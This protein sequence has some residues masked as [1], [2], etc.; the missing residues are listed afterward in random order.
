MKIIH[1]ARLYHPHVGGIEKHLEKINKKFIDKGHS[2]T[3]ITQQYKTNLP[4]KEKKDKVNIIRLARVKKEEFYKNK[5]LYKIQTWLGIFKNLNTL[6]KADII[7][8]HDVMWWLLPFYFLLWNKIYITFH[9]YEGNDE[10]KFNQIFW[11]KLANILTRGNLCVG[12]FHQKWYKVNPTITTFGAVKSLENKSG[13]TLKSKNKK[14]IFIGRLAA[15]NGIINYLKALKILKDKGH[16]YSLDVYGDGPLLKKSRKFVK[17]NNLKVVFHGA[18]NNAQKFLPKYNLGF[19]SRYLGILE[20][21]SAKVYVI[22]QY[23]NQIKKDYLKLSPFGEWIDIVSSADNIA[24]AVLSKQKL[25][26]KDLNNIKKSQKWANAQTWER[27]TENYL[28]LWQS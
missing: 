15:D 14:I 10:P 23:N 8:V 6:F 1:L 19:I 17:K 27:M 20:A 16:N 24:D 13:G 28:K 5:I 11:H 25:T 3:V 12:S 7:H 2:V 21:L 9:G 22:A 18:V 26:Q 4:I